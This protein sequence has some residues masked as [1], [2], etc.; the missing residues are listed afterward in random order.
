MTAPSR[1]GTPGSQRC[2]AI[3]LRV[4]VRGGRTESLG[5]ARRPSTG[6]ADSFWLVV[7]MRPALERTQFPW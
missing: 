3:L 4:A 1:A 6:K 5:A 7:S 2:S